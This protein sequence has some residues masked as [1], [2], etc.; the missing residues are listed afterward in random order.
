MWALRKRAGPGSLQSSPLL[1]SLE[2]ATAEAGVVALLS[3]EGARAWRVRSSLTCTPGPAFSLEL[4]HAGRG[5]EGL[6]GGPG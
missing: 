3:T 2:Q 5:A 1:A 4:Q 6:A